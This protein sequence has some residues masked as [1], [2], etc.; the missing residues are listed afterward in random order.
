MD[1]PTSANMKR[2]LSEE[3]MNYLLHFP[4]IVVVVDQVDDG[5]SVGN[6]TIDSSDPSPEWEDPNATLVIE[7]GRPLEDELW[8]H[9]VLPRGEVVR[10]LVN[11]IL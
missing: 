3:F 2:L 4:N 8:F 6:D 7:T 5:R 11:S 1:F 10:L 9:G